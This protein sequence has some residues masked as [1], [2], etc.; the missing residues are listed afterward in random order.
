M[1]LC[2]PTFFQIILCRVIPLGISHCRGDNPYTSAP[3][4]GVIRSYDFTVSR[5]VIAPDGFQKSVILINGAFPGPLIEANWG[6][7]IQVTLHNQISGPEEGTS[8]HWHG[9]LQRGTNGWTVCLAC[10]NVLSRQALLLPIHL[11][12]IFTARPGIT[13]IT[14]HNMQV[15]YVV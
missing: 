15:C 11:R 9:I 14:R 5:G 10:N 4:T 2:C 12:L 1:L 6:D 8:L 7:T 3:T 13:L